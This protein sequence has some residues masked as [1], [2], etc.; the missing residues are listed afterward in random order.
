MALRSM[1]TMSADISSV[2]QNYLSVCIKDLKFP[3]CFLIKIYFSSW[4]NKSVTG[5]YKTASDYQSSSR[6]CLIAL[7]TTGRVTGFSRIVLIPSALASETC[8]L[9]EKPLT[10]RAFWAGLM[11]SILR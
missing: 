11:S 1:F 10:T 4:V 6:V 3:G 8:S 2:L 7:L 9:S 5:D